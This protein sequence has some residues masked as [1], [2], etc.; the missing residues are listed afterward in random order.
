[1]KVS[2][3][4]VCRNNVDTIAATLESVARQDYPDKEHIVIDGASNDGT[5]EI[6]NK[7][8]SGIS[9]LVSEKD[10][11]LYFALNKG[12]A[13]ASGEMICILHADDVYAHNQVI[14]R[15]VELIKSSGCAA[16]YGDLEYVDQQDTDRIVR[17]WISGP[18]RRER[19]MEG[20]MPPHPAFFILKKCYNEFGMFDTSLHISADYELMLRILYKNKVEAA[21]LPEVLVKMR[22]G[23]TSNA[24]ISSRI[25]ANREDR[26][27]WKMNGLKPGMFTLIRKPL[28]K[29]RQFFTR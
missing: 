7:H 8:R 21:Y 4:T 27:A 16:V 29:L 20:W 9:Q 14:S 17:S 15:V 25:Q 10:D 2:I 11:G 5:L 6:L 12:I 3:I 1:M 22:T 26:L 18:Y 13:L 23:G 24:G 28:S 19:F